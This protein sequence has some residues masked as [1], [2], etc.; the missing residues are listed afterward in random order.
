VEEALIFMMM[1]EKYSTMKRGIIHLPGFLRDI[2]E[3][4][5]KE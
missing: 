1:T 4:D 5:F 2:V 3:P